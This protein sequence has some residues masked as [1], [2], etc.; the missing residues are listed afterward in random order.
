[1]IKGGHFDPYMRE[2]NIAS[3]AAIDWFRTHLA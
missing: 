1:M 2:F 3:G